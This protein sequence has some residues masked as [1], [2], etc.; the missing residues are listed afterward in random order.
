MEIRMEWKCGGKK[1]ARRKAPLWCSK[2][3]KSARGV[4]SGMVQVPRRV[5]NPERKAKREE[6]GS[7]CACACAWNWVGKSGGGGCGRGDGVRSWRGESGQQ[8]QNE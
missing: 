2:D 8:E 7:V 3:G 5:R 6:K 1:K 4:S